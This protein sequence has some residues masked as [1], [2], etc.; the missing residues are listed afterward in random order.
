[1]GNKTSLATRR[2]SADQTSFLAIFAARLI[3]DEIKKASASEHELHTRK[4]ITLRYG[5]KL[6]C[7]EKNTSHRESRVNERRKRPGV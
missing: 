1:M 7:S 6:T 5:N 2:S 4:V 3:R